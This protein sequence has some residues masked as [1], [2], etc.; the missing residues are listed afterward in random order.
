MPQR[1][2]FS[3]YNENTGY[4]G[5]YLSPRYFVS[6]INIHEKKCVYF[7]VNVDFWTL[8]R[9][10]KKSYLY[11][12]LFKMLSSMSIYEIH[13]IFT[14]LI[15]YLIVNEDWRTEGHDNVTHSNKC[16]DFKF[17]GRDEFI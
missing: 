11:E 12:Y 14:T 8:F 13:F 15:S 4:G 10:R 3:L 9:F 1:Y 17:W 2:I 16:G 7:I 5:Y 6:W